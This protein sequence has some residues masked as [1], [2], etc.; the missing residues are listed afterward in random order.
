MNANQDVKDR[1]GS[2]LFWKLDSLKMFLLQ[3]LFPPFDYPQVIPSVVSAMILLINFQSTPPTSSST[4][5]VPKSQ[6][7]HL[8]RSLS[9]SGSVLVGLIGLQHPN[10]G[11]SLYWCHPTGRSLQFGGFYF[12]RSQGLS[13]GR[14][15]RCS[16]SVLGYRGHWSFSDVSLLHLRMSLAVSTWGNSVELLEITVDGLGKH[17]AWPRVELHC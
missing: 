13:G 2:V 5:I 12:P 9:L 15:T 14:P 7:F 3:W 17:S 8:V 4:D 10:S 1:L 16:W 11:R 6:F